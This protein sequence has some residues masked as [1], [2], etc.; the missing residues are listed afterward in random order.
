MKFMNLFEV[1]GMDNG[2]EL[3]IHTCLHRYTI[4]AGYYENATIEIPISEVEETLI[5]RL[6][7]EKCVSPSGLG[8]LLFSEAILHIRKRVAVDG[9]LCDAGTENVRI[10][11]HHAFRWYLA[12]VG[13][14]V[15]WETMSVE[16]LKKRFLMNRQENFVTS[17]NNIV[18][19]RTAISY[20][21]ADKWAMKHCGKPIDALLIWLCNRLKGLPVGSA[22]QVK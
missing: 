17:D 18:G 7:M 2:Q 12:H 16:V 5:L 4:S 19:V 13:K 1:F 20:S 15:I 22:L 11:L 21:A 14:S 6:P 10:S 3:N 9:L 8:N